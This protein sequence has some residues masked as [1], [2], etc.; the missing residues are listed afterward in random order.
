MDRRARVLLCLLLAF[1]LMNSVH[2]SSKDEDEEPVCDLKCV[3]DIINI[4]MFVFA[5]GP[6]EVVPRLVALAVSTL[7]LLV[8][9]A[10]LACI[11]SCCGIE[12]PSERRRGSHEHSTLSWGLTWINTYNNANDVAANWHKWQ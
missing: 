1:C 11:C 2:A 5:G 3:L 9:A 10:L 12:P 4:V 7:I 8:V 6:D